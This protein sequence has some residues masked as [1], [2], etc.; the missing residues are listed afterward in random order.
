MC[1]ETRFRLAMDRGHDVIALSGFLTGAAGPA[2]AGRPFRFDVSASDAI[3]LAAADLLDV[4]VAGSA[5]VRK[6]ASPGGYVSY[7]IDPAVASGAG[8]AIEPI[9]AKRLL[10]HLPD[11]YEPAWYLELIGGPSGSTG[12]M[13]YAYV[14]SAADG[15][16]LYCH[17]MTASDT[18]TYRV[19]ADPAGDHLP[20]DGP[21]GNDP[22]PHPTGMPDGYQAP[23]LPPVLLTLQNGPISTN[24]PW[25][26]PTATVTTG[27]NV[28]AYA[29]LSSPDGFGAGDLRA[30]TTATRTFDRTYDTALAPQVSQTQEMAAVTQL[31]YAN[32]FFHDWYYDSGF[33]EVSRNAQ[34]NNYGRGGIGNDSIRAEAQDYSGRN[35]ADMSTPADGGRPRMQM[36]VFDGN[37]LNQV[38]VN[39]PPSIAGTYTTGL[40]AFG[41]AV[42]D[43]TADLVLVDDGVGVVTDGC[44]TPFVNAGALAGKIALIDRGSCTFVSKVKNAQNAGAAGVIIANNTTGVITMGGTDATITI[45]SLMISIDDGNIIK[46]ELAGGVNA[47]L[48]RESA[49]DRDGTIDNQIVAHEWGH[50]ISNRLIGNGSGLNTN[51]A[52]G[53]GE[54]WSDFHALLMTVRPEDALVTGNESYQGT[55]GLAGYVSSGGANQG[56]YYGIRRVPYSTDL[57]RDPL[58]FKHISDG[59]PLPTTAPIAFGADGSSNSEVHNT[60]EVWAT[61]LWEC[62]AA[63]LR[64]TVGP[65]P[66]LTFQQAQDRMKDYLVAAYKLTPVS[67]TLLEARDALL[68]AAGANDPVDRALLN[69]AFAKRG[70]GIGAIAPNRFST[71]NVGVVESYLA[72]DDLVLSDATLVDDVSTLCQ[73]DGIL[74]DGETGHL[75]FTLLNTSSSS[76]TS[77][78]ATVTSSDPGVSFPAGNTISLPPAAA[79]GTTTGSVE[80]SL[81]GLSGIQLREFSITYD[82]PGLLV[83]G[84][85]VATTGFRVNADEQTA[86]SATDDV[87]ATSTAWTPG[88]NPSLDV[89]MPWQRV[90]LSPL[91][92]D[93]YGADTGASSD[94]YLVSPPLSVAPTGSFSFTFNHRYVFESSAGSDYDGG[95]IEISVDNGPWSDIGGS[96]SPGYTGS[97]EVG[98]LNPIE[99]R[100]AFTGQSPGYPGFTAVTVNLGTAYQGQ[101]VRVRFR[102]GTDISVGA[103]GWEIDDLAFANIINLPF[104]TLSGHDGTCDADTDGVYDTIDCAPA[105][106][107]LWAPSS[108]ALDLTL[109]AGAP[110]TLSWSAPASPGAS[111]GEVYDVLRGDGSPDFTTAACALSGG[112]GLSLQD[113]DDPAVIF[114]YLVRARNACGGS[115]GAA[116]SGTPRTGATCP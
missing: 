6:G 54:G 5:F 106:G 61:M 99:G 95:V 69:Q 76:L 60:G 59:V 100:N 28:D 92:H 46:P 105:D 3:A 33:D 13:T 111:T 38:T 16:L 22:T 27:N 91:S 8:I 84:P 53:L 89:S 41:P 74:D 32:N 104:A 85:R 82:D 71:D 11:R 72:G 103:T 47:N 50:Y 14:I 114:Y 37:G 81:N 19:W 23:L 88:N 66:R 43:L 65:S 20:T 113:S 55:Y 18:F 67:P 7:E 56:Y 109:D 96:A 34:T 44:E 108:E 64:D 90:E 98:G 24:D 29:D 42:F 4:N 31:F 57:T 86:Q 116:S 45:P 9:R 1:S 12:A 93:W 63:L 58:T 26:A 51:M 110:T 97:L 2:A 10:F 79:S 39:T 94:Q 68:A 30:S 15:R 36:Y 83:P 73:P 78:T 102:I 40:A 17:D 49:I 107:T 35:N 48:L 62:Y 70:A 80:V 25:L 75:T 101:S 112:P 52:G 87:E 115:L 77:T 21:Q